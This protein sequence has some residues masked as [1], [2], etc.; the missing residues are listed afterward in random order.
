MRKKII[1]LIKL[2]NF[3][4]ICFLFL[5]ICKSVQ[6]QS[7]FNPAYLISDRSFVDY[8]SMTKEE[9]NFFL[10]NKAGA[11]ADYQTI[12]PEGNIKTA[13]EIIY[14]AGQKYQINPMV[15]LT[16]LQKE[17]SLITH[18]NPK[19]SQ[20]DWAMGFGC[21]DNR[22]P[23]ERFRGFAHQVDRAAWRL[24]YFLEN[25]WE[26]VFRPGQNYTISGLMVMPENSATAA[27]YNYTPHL[28]G[29]KIFWK[30]WQN[31]FG[32]ITTDIEN[33]TPV[34]LINEP[35]IWLIENDKRRPFFSRN[36]FL[37]SYSFKD[38][39]IISREKLFK[40]QIG[41]PMVFPNYSLLKNP[42]DE[43]YLKVDKTIR[44]VR[45]EIFRQIGFHPE[46]I[47]LADAKDLSNYQLGKPITSSYPQGA[48]LQN[49]TTKEVFWVEDEKKHPVIHPSIARVNFPHQS[50]NEVDKSLLDR[51][52][53]GPTIKFRDGVLL[54]SSTGP[55]I[56][57]ISLGKKRRISSIETFAEFGYRW[58]DIFI[59]PN[60]VLELHQTGQPIRLQ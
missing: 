60:H 24:R 48:L 53:L 25:S 47:I 16:L 52:E 31:W 54:K 23:I 3:F 46:E 20:Y 40:Y 15:L 28:H 44:L 56:Y 37:A 58:E 50:I 22:P 35:G 59:V 14:Q 39:V 30:I 1:S 27:L 43:I 7:N 36:V 8:Q 34:K 32:K 42:D 10:K 57:I 55:N 38:V 17:Q 5:T 2:V 4:V 29:N 9:I 21:Y 13:A 26:F 49:Q 19:T 41:E 18:K 11:L 51:I 6:A 12:D 45:P 33:R